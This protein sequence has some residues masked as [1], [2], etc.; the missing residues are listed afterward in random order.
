MKKIELS[1][2]MYS[3]HDL[4]RLYDNEE[5]VV[6]PKY[7]RRRTA[8]P[9]NAKSGLIDTIVSNYPIPPIYIRSFVDSKRRRKTEIIDGQQRIT[10]IMEFLNGDFA[11]TS[12]FSDR[13]LVGATY[14]ELP[15]DIQ[16]SI[17]DYELSC[18]AIR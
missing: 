14:Q 5:I 8:W 1:Y 9:P 12:T 11:L 17:T 18:M 6:Q 4:K 15:N 10:T 2:R 3:I 16:D 7:Q 13:D